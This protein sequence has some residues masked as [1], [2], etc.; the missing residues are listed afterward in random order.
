MIYLDNPFSIANIIDYLIYDKDLTKSNPVTRQV[1]KV[2]E[3]DELKIKTMLYL[4]EDDCVYFNGETFKLDKADYKDILSIENRD[5]N[6]R[7]FQLTVS[8]NRHPQALPIAPLNLFLVSNVCPNIPKQVSY[9][10]D[11]EEAGGEEFV[12]YDHQVNILEASKLYWVGDDGLI[13]LVLFRDEIL[14]CLKEFK[15]IHAPT[16]KFLD[17]YKRNS[18]YYN[19]VDYWTDWV[20][21]DLTATIFNLIIGAFIIS[22]QLPKIYMES[23]FIFDMTIVDDTVPDDPVDYTWDSYALAVYSALEKGLMVVRNISQP[24]AS[25]VLKTFLYDI[26]YRD[27]ISARNISKDIYYQFSKIVDLVDEF[28]KNKYW[29]IEFDL[30]YMRLN[31]LSMNLN[32][33]S[34]I[35]GHV[36]QVHTNPKKE[37]KK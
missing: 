17:K 35:N 15:S 30:A 8:P 27:P 13:N 11:V 7:K 3:D 34:S 12:P 36:F 29:E 32:Y 31:Q 24:Q 23:D 14:V 37:K 4:K 5:I 28:V 6:I 18:K 20:T 2:T 33:T 1:Q 19:T 25:V 9:L 22:G 26:I 21:T 10:M 16:G